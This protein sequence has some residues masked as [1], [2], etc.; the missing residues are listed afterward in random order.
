MRKEAEDLAAKLWNLVNAVSENGGVPLLKAKREQLKAISESIE[1]LS[2]P[3]DLHGLK[4]S[5]TDEIEK[6]VSDQVVLYFLKEQLSQILDTI[7]NNGSS[8]TVNQSPGT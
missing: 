1:Q 4:K 8:D 6:V 2:L 7:E 3:D 5:L